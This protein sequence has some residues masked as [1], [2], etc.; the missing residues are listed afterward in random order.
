MNTSTNIEAELSAL[1]S[2][3]EVEI[4]ND[5]KSVDQLRKR[6]EKN[7]NL[8]KAIKASLS[9]ISPATTDY[10]TKSASIR[11]AISK[12]PTPQFTQSNVEEELRKI[13]PKMEINR[14][15]IRSALWTM[16]V[17]EDAPIR[18]VRKGTNKEPAL[19][20]KADNTAPAPR[21]AETKKVQEA[22]ISLAPRTTP[23]SPNE[24]EQ[25]VRHKS[26][27]INDLAARLRTTATQITS[28]LDPASKVYVADKGWLKIKE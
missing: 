28:L 8:L 9:V 13:N 15:R 17:A 1:Q 14:S 25:A 26:G 19:Y 23:V 16:A 2:K 21:T 7:E 24:L 6:I 22:R 10:G 12:I 5:V 27:R 3:L 11:E 4:A 18:V 20:E